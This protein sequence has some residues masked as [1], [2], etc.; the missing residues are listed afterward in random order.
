MVVARLR[1]FTFTF[2]HVTVVTVI[3]FY[4]YILILDLPRLRPH[5]PVGCCC[6]GYV[7]FTLRLRL[8]SFD[9]RFALFP[10]CCYYVWIYAF[11]V[12]YIYGLI[13]VTFCYVCL[14]CCLVTL[15]YVVRLFVG[16]C[17]C[18]F[19]LLVY[20]CSPVTFGYV[21]TV[22]VYGYFAVHT[23]Y[24]PRIRSVYVYLYALH[25]Y[26]LRYVCDCCVGSLPVTRL[27]GCIYHVVLRLAFAVYP[28][29]HFTL[30][31]VI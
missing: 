20:G 4:G 18:D 3:T 15:F 24:G 26:G 11:V 16:C 19:T 14:R 13:L 7:W 29:L 10:V 30:G 25:V 28:G 9:L 12:V 31:Y 21:Y 5:V 23:V 6:Y 22:T 17:G 1:L 27:L 2:W 8:R